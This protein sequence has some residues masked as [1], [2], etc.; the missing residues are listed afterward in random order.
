[1][2]KRL[3]EKIETKEFT[4]EDVNFILKIQQELKEK[5][6]LDFFC[7]KMFIDL[8]S[9]IQS[10]GSLFGRIAYLGDEPV[11]FVF[12]DT[13][14]KWYSGPECGWLISIFVLPEYRRQGI[15]RRLIVEFFDKVR[16]L[17]LRKVC[18][19]VEFTNEETL[20]F[21]RK[22]GFKRSKFIHL[23]KQIY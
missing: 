21:L 4:M 9:E 18:V 13:R 8:L 5:S 3:F 6:G 1:M 17:G 16:E 7:D 2:K 12:G 11:G 20:A 10:S 14:P 22:M 23:E 19:A 15:G